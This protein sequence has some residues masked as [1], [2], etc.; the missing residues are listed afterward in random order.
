M[1]VEDPPL[2]KKPGSVN[3][4]GAVCGVEVESPGPKAEL[5]PEAESAGAGVSPGLVK[6]GPVSS[7]FS[8][9]APNDELAPGPLVPEEPSVF[10][11]V[12]MNGSTLPPVLGGVPPPGAEGSAGLSPDVPPALESVPFVPEAGVPDPS[13]VPDASDPEVVEPPVELPPELAPL[14]PPDEPPPAAAPPAFCATAIPPQHRPAR[15]IEIHCRLEIMALLS[16]RVWMNLR[17]LRGT[18]HIGL[19]DAPEPRN[20]LISSSQFAA[21]GERVKGI[22]PS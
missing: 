20:S 16:S 7:R 6:F 4:G 18:E 10:G 13:E 2:P 3:D 5:G 22:E 21:E 17:A 9:G 11:V 15:Q 14:D 19:P 8:G 1:Y 12:G